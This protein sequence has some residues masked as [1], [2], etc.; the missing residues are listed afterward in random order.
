MGAAT[1]I[2]GLLSPLFMNIINKIFP[3][4][5][6]ASE[7]QAEMQRLLI[8]AQQEAYKADAAAME[9]KKE[10]IVTEMNQ[11]G[12]ASQW[13]SYVMIMCTAMIGFNWMIAP[14][15][16]SVLSL[17]GMTIVTTVIPSEVWTVL[18]IG[19]GGY[20]TKETMNVYAQGKV[21]K[22]RA[23]NP[24]P[25]IDEKAFADALRKTIFKDGMTEA[26]W[27]ALQKAASDSVRHE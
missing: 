26:Q 7:A 11:G 15:L 18:S 6:K 10:V 14:L 2:I 13:R 8:E 5:V 16:N 21:D 17:L 22:A 3:D 12:W 25:F 1:A 4:P 19:L 23:E 9:A 27:K 24:P 20:L